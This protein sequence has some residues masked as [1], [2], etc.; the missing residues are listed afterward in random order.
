MIPE[1]S[2]ACPD[3]EMR[4]VA[5]PRQSLIPHPPLFQA[6][7]DAAVAVFK[8]LSI[9]DANWIEDP[10]TGEMRPPTFGEAC[11]EWVF[12]F[13]AAI[14]GAYDE[15]TRKRYINE[16]FLLISKKNSKSTLA[17]GIMVTALIRN[18]RISAELLILA[19]T[20]EIAENAFKPAA[21]MIAANDELKKLLH[22]QEH[23]RTIK[24]RVTGA[25]LKVVAA[26]SE[27]VG[28]KKAAFIL[29]DELW[30][31]GK[32]P[33][34]KAMLREAT[35]GLVSRP[36]GFVIYLSTHSDEAPAGVFK[37]KLQ[38]FRDV[39]D[40]VIVDKTCLGVFYEWPK[41]LIEDKAYEDPA[42]FYITNPNLGRS[43]S[44]EWLE[45]ELKKEQ[46]GEGDGIQVFY[47]K[48]L[49]LEIGLRLARDRWRGADY[50]EDAEDEALKSLDALLARAEVAVIGID[51]GGLDDLLGFCVAGRCKTTKD[52]LYWF[53]AWAQSDVFERR[54]DIASKLADFKRDGDLILCAD[55]TQDIED[56][57]AIVKQV[58]EA[59]LLPEKAAIG[60]DPQGVAAL[61]DE[62][63]AAGVADEQIVGISQGYRLSS[64]VWGL[65]RK[66]KDG[67]AWHGGQP[68]MDFC[69]GNAKAI[70]R[71]NAVLIDKQQSGKAKID[72]L[73][74]GFNATK[75]LE[76]NPVAGGRSVYEER[77]VL[78]V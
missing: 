75:L 13:V 74:A 66:L 65:E 50:W 39:R 20:R 29:V 64:A 73:C 33:N 68:L 40:G 22:V 15:K 16:F 42:N 63:S 67:T 55:P 9:V 24:H 46:R 60:V 19:P 7:A 48:H 71:G 21:D 57:A 23:K 30:L 11:E 1:W 70:Q 4:I 26:D 34:A 17:A 62:L 2:T 69:V 35:G 44:Q 56:V 10:E 78:S 53:R 54:K 3:W 37:E 58:N 72:P 28:G 14:F 61:I 45:N 77:G 51:G 8:S 43:V 36:E 38:Y 76:R 18:R 31:F 52:W 6:E 41:Q 49:N 32:K 25:E 59:G 47:A 12:E 27:V 5:R